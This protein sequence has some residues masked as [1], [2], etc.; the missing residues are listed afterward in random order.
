[1]AVASREP[2]ESYNLQSRLKAIALSSREMIVLSVSLD[3]VV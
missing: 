1:V 3:A 2:Q